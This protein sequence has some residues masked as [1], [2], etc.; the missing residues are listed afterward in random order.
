M[1]TKIQKSTKTIIAIFMILALV[2]LTACSIQGRVVESNDKITIGSL[3]PLTGDASQWG[4]PP[5]EG[6][7]LAL[8]QLGGNLAG[9]PVN[10][11]YEDD[12]CDPSKAVTAVQ[13]LI[14]VDHVDAIVGPV[15]SS[16]T[17]AIA[18]L[19]EAAGVALISPAS[20][21]EKVSQAGDYIFRVIPSDALRGDVFAKYMKQKGIN[22]VA[23]L[24]ANTDGTATAKISFARTFEQM[25]GKVTIA[26][27]YEQDARDL[28]TQLLKIK[29]KEKETDALLFISY[30]ADTIV[31]LKQ[32]QEL[33]LNLPMYSPGESPEDDSVPQS[34]GNAAEDV[35]YILPA[36]ATGNQVN[37]FKQTFQAKF[38]K[39]PAL[40]AAEAFDAFNIIMQSAQQCESAKK[41]GTC[42]KDNL[43]KV[44][45]YQG[46]SGIISFDNNGDVVK[47]MAIKQIKNGQN[48]VVEV[49]G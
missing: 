1:I 23:V 40:F 27:V 28:R 14:N 7:E 46:A 49:I 17:M 32:A 22:N 26:E 2:S 13:K 11:I 48:Q 15:C 42:I 25:G 16:A 18:P 45:D 21:S 12:Q 38:S 5:K 33:G 20:T 47:P 31:I 37:K 34:A 10:V 6:V 8:A 35:V 9:R 19:V 3:G 39:E 36:E 24:Y 43:Y 29:D 4:L 41:L 44:Q 30:V